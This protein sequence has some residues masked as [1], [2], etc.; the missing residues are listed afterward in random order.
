MQDAAHLTMILDIT[1][2]ASL[3]DFCHEDFWPEKSF[4]KF[5]GGYLKISLRNTRGQL[6]K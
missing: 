5:Y 4:K 3:I 2:S 6:R 1:T